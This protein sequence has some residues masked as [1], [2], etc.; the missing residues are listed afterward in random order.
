MSDL[1]ERAMEEESIGPPF[2]VGLL[3]INNVYSI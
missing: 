2:Q 1:V 3:I